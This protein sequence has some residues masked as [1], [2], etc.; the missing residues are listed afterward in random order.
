MTLTGNKDKASLTF[1]KFCLR[2]PGDG[3]PLKKVT[4]VTEL[5]NPPEA[6]NKYIISKNRS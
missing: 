3:I 1:P 6:V 2:V 4:N 5:K